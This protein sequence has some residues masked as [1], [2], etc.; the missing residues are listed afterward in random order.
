[1]SESCDGR[2]RGKGGGIGAGEGVLIE[3]D[4]TSV[5]FSSS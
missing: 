3:T 5:K 4:V 1:M 2:D